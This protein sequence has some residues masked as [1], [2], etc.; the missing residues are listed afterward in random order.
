MLR[1]LAAQAAPGTEAL[2]ACFAPDAVVKDEGQSHTGLAAIA[3]WKASTDKKY[4]VT[5][6]PLG[7]TRRGVAESAE[8][9]EE[10]R[11]LVHLEGNFPG[12]RVELMLVFTVQGELVTALHIRSPVELEGRRALVTG[13]TR[14]I[15]Q[16]VVA[17][18][19]QAG[20][21][22]LTAA[23][24]R[25]ADMADA[26]GAA[27]A[28]PV[29]FVA[30]DVSTAEGC[31]TVVQAVEAQLGGVDIVVH[32]PG[33][34]SAPAG[35]YQVLG[36]D[37][38]DSALAVNLYA[39]VRLDR[40]LLPGMVARG[41]G[42]VVHITS[43]LRLMPLPEATTAYSAAKAALSTYSKSLSKEVAAGGVRVVRVAPGWVET[44]ASTRLVK[45]I[46]TE[47]GTDLEA[48]RQTLMASRGGIP[49][50]RPA[51]PGEV[52]DLVGF[53]VSARAASITGVEYVIDGGTVPV[54]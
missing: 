52:A 47:S 8:G 32:V 2:A 3:R 35:G 41:V 24:S 16:A 11:L 40:A 49:I 51:R 46:A 26:P 42:V 7:F 1:Y 43:I 19:L 37:E 15:G 36:D 10:V 33:G 50:G 4:Q 9:A 53:L 25:P 31:A 48:A 14:G 13:G 21:T 45:R 6:T 38:W 22:V 17:Q 20:A 12:K 28:K 44:E 18:L 27:G 30:A 23:R 39:A 34:S 54:A 29:R 5:F